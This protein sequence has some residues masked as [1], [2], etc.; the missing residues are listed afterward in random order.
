[1][2]QGWVVG[3]DKYHFGKAGSEK[4]YK[5]ER[6]KEEKAKKTSQCRHN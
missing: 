6:K 4:V 1:L 3:K 2:E 5:K